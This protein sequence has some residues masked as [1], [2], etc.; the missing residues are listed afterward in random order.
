MIKIIKTNKFKI[1][2][3]VLVLT[4]IVSCVLWNTTR[5]HAQ[6]LTIDNTN[7]QAFAGARAITNGKL[8]GTAADHAT[9]SVFVI[10][11]SQDKFMANN[12][13]WEHDGTGW[14]S[15]DKVLFAG[16]NSEQQIY[17]CAPYTTNIV[18][19]SIPVTASE[20][21][22]WLVAPAADLIAESIDIPMTHALSKIVL[23]FTF[24]TETRSATVHQVEIQDMYASGNLDI[25]SNTWSNLSATTTLK[26]E[27]NELLVIPKENC[28][29]F[30][31][32]ITMTDNRKFTTTIDLTGVGSK[33]AAGTQYNITLQVGQDVINVQG[34]NAD[35][36]ILTTGG[37]LKTE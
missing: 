1:T 16:V 31:I 33:L 13:K 30:N 27:N 23:D 32:V 3:F 17:A 37:D 10:N 28:N 14:T 9:M 19:G 11:G 18:N 35:P 21:I 7:V 12:M 24:G 2:A 5:V 25:A 4:L 26:T 22:D 36:W 8:V 20:Q 6:E 34:I 15:N 29:S